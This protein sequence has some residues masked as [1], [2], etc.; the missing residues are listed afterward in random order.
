MTDDV[1]D[2]VTDDYGADNDD[3]DSRADGVSIFIFF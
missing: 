3:V 2:D 1:A